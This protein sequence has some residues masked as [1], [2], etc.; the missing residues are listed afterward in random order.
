MYVLESSC[1]PL[2]SM[3]FHLL[4]FVDS[5]MVNVPRRYHCNIT[6]IFFFFVLCRTSDASASGLGASA[7]HHCA[8]SRLNVLRGALMIGACVAGVVVGGPV[9]S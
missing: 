9:D 1:G 8:A 4:S 7:V 5:D 6:V 3:V 2:G